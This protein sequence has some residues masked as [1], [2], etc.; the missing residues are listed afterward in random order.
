MIRVSCFVKTLGGDL[1]RFRSKGLTAGELEKP[2]FVIRGT[3]LQAVLLERGRRLV[4]IEVKSNGHG[5]NRS[6]RD[7]FD[8]RFKPQRSLLVGGDGISIEEF[9]SVPAARWFD[10]AP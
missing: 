6:G 10:E 4:S 3:T 5:V 9:L 2:G 1:V 8:E 7:Q